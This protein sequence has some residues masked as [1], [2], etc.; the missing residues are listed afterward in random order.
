MSEDTRLRDELARE[1]TVL[2]NERTL[3]AYARTALGL[4]ALAVLVFK[5]ASPEI[6]MIVGATALTGALFVAAWGI[7]SYR[8]IDSRIHGGTGI[9]IVSGWRVF[10]ARF[11][12]ARKENITSDSA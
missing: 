2:A 1:R 5:F 6:A 8:R 4:V 11:G 9:D 3:L 12:F 10:T 7:H